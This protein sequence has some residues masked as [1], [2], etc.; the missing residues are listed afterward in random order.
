MGMFRLKTRV[1]RSLVLA[2]G[3]SLLTVRGRN[4]AGHDSLI[5]LWVQ[6]A[7]IPWANLEMLALKSCHTGANK[8]PAWN[9]SRS[10]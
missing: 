5:K 6:I 4:Q 7:E 1:Q 2:M 3:V 8:G 10:L 9:Q